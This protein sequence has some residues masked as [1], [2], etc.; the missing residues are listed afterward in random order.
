MNIALAYCAAER[1]F[2]LSLVIRM[3]LLSAEYTTSCQLSFERETKEANV[4]DGSYGV[5]KC[6]G[7]SR[8][9]V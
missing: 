1:V 6:G 5:M 9:Q 8:G 4:G 2:E 3:L 7:S